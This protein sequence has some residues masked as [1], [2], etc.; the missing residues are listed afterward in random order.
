MLSG[1]IRSLPSDKQIYDGSFI[2]LKNLN[3]GY[4]LK[5]KGSTSMR[6]YCA[7][8]NLFTWTNYP[9]FDPETTSFNKDPQRRGVD[10]GGYPGTKN[11]SLGLQFNY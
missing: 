3:I 8:Q 11:Y 10:F 1:G 9:G 2:R 5:F 4:T 7:A 6:V